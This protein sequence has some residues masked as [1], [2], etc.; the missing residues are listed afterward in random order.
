M[1]KRQNWISN[2]YFFR[3]PRRLSPFSDCLMSQCNAD[4]ANISSHHESSMRSEKQPDAMTNDLCGEAMTMIERVAHQW[5]MP[6]IHSKLHFSRGSVHPCNLWLNQLIEAQA[7]MQRYFSC[8][9]RKAGYRI[10][11]VLS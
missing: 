11:K 9:A 3:S 2:Y 8:R 7:L 5:S 10:A 1:K 4:I 6:Q